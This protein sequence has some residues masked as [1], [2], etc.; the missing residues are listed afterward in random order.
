[1]MI[2]DLFR[3]DIGKIVKLGI[4]YVEDLM[5]IEKYVLVL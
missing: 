3:N 5:F 1:M 4:V 2:V